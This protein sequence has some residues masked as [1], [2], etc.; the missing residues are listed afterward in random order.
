MRDADALQVARRDIATLLEEK[1]TLLDTVRS[2]QTQLSAMSMPPTPS[3]EA[4]KSGGF[5]R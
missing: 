5:S 1:R 2:L 3:P 4:P